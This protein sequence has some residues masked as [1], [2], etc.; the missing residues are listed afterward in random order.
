MLFYSYLQ[1]LECLNHLKQLNFLSI[2]VVIIIML[3]VQRDVQ[4]KCNTVLLYENET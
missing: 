4:P 1:H 2:S 3:G